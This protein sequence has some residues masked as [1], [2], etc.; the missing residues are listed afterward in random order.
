MFSPEPRERDGFPHLCL[1]QTV[2]EQLSNQR[3]RPGLA[4]RQ[5]RGALMAQRSNRDAHAGPH[6]QLSTADRGVFVDLEG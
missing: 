3:K 1:Y 2:A 4:T 6:E 5:Y